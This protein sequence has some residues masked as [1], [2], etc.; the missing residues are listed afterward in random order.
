MIPLKNYLMFGHKIGSI[1]QAPTSHFS[2]AS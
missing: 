1:I 2:K